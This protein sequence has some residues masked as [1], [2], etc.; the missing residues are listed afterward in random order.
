MIYGTYPEV[1]IS[2]TRNAKIEVV[3]EIAGSY[4]LKDVLVFERVRSSS[5]L[6]DLLKLLAF[7]VGSDVSHN[8]LSVSLGVDVKTV[9]R[10]LDLLEKAIV[11]FRFVG[12]S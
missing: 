8:E 11:I 6:W 12:F 4:L 5:K 9:Q 2:K 1:I 3:S 10:H 7:Q